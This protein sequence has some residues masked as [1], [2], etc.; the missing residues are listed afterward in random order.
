MLVLRKPMVDWVT[1]TTFSHSVGDGWKLKLLQEGELIRLEDRKD[2]RHLQYDGMRIPAD[3]GTIFWGVGTQGRGRRRH[4]ILM[5][6]GRLADEFVMGEFSYMTRDDD[7]DKINCTRIDIQVTEFDADV[8]VPKSWS[9]SFLKE[10]FSGQQKREGVAVSWI[11]DNAKES[12]IA[13]IGI[14]KRMGETYYRIYAKPSY[15]GHAIRLE[16]EYKGD[17]ATSCLAAIREGGGRSKIGEILRYQLERLHSGELEKFFSSALP[18]GGYRFPTITRTG[19]GNTEMWLMGV[20]LPAYERFIATNERG[21][22]I[23]R[24]FG[25]AAGRGGDAWDLS[26]RWRES[27]VVVT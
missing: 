7:K 1:F 12:A 21:D 25:E 8:L 23:A 24:A 19:Q 9:L 13:T 26:G 20:V 27:D 16:M 2:A 6:S 15:K 18:E 3:G 14:G 5:V 4:W 10:V 11:Q 17:K 22:Y